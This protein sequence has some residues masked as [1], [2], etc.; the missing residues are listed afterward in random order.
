MASLHAD[1]NSSAAGDESIT[2]KCRV[3]NEKLDQLLGTLHEEASPVHSAGTPRVS[4]DEEDLPDEQ[5]EHPEMMKS[6]KEAKECRNEGRAARQKG[7]RKVVSSLSV[8]PRFVRLIKRNYLFFFAS[9]SYQRTKFNQREA[10]MSRA[11]SLKKAVRQIIEHAE[12]A[13]DE[14]N[15]IQ[16][17]R[18]THSAN[19]SQNSGYGV[20][21]SDI[22]L[23]VT[24]PDDSSSGEHAKEN[25]A[26][27]AAA[28][29]AAMP[30]ALLQLYSAISGA[31]DSSSEPSPCPSPIPMAPSLTTNFP[32]LPTSPIRYP[33]PP[34][35]YRMATPP[36]TQPQRPRSCNSEAPMRATSPRPPGPCVAHQESAESEGDED[37]SAM[38]SLQAKLNAISPVPDAS[39]TRTSCEFDF[40]ALALPV[41][42]EFADT[43]SLQD[44]PIDVFDEETDVRENLPSQYSPSLGE[45]CLFPINLKLI[46]FS[47]HL[48]RSGAG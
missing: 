39:E 14:Q 36:N 15:G 13:L 26:L 18:S 11:N 29:A 43:D 38:L 40:S 6:S 34:V 19:A 25:D 10:L 20:S 3:L 37:R 4:I 24:H 28:K 41:P 42:L 8:F 22:K 30:M 21:G 27:A 1:E 12:R 2:H 7:A 44:V 32:L 45:I 9:Q 48:F 5:P 35:F 31:G 17:S 46:F 23:I 16:A 33:N 47:F